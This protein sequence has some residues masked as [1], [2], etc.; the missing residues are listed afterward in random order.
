MVC[1][2]RGAAGSRSTKRLPSSSFIDLS[3]PS[4]GEP[5]DYTSGNDQTSVLALS[6]FWRAVESRSSCS[7]VVSSPARSL[8]AKSACAS[9]NSASATTYI[10]RAR[11]WLFRA[12]HAISSRPLYVL[13]VI[14]FLAVP[15][16]AYLMHDPCPL[17]AGLQIENMKRLRRRRRDHASTIHHEEETM[18]EQC[19]RSDAR[20]TVSRQC[21]RPL[22]K[23]RACTIEARQR[24]SRG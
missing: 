13:P 21:A 10:A 19:Q 2:Q 14:D 22:R 23:S 15:T 12:S 24:R 5:Q 7:G 20:R 16:S 8:A 17:S 9:S 11:A 4:R 6:R 3:R 18:S 1:G